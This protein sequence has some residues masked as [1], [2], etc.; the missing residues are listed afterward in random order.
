MRAIIV[1]G[2]PEAQLP[3]NIRPADGD[4]LVAVDLGGSHCLRWGWQPAVVIG[5]LDSLP[6][7]DEA[8]LRAM[9]CRF[10][11]VPVRKD[12]TDLELALDHAV[13]AGASEIVIVAAWGG[14]IDQSL[15]NVLLLTRPTLTGRDVRLVEGRQTVRLAQP[16]R[17]AWIEGLPGDVLSL[18]PVGG[19]ADGVEVDDVEW[20]LHGESLALGVTRGVSNVLTGRAVRV[21]VRSGMLVVTHDACPSGVQP[22]VQ[23]PG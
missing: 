16:G 6:A 5:D 13:Q 1:A 10:I 21:R 12:E 18:V 3:V 2:S 19:D 17:P 20:P 7:S 23:T 14:R 9:G 4:L 15:A 11:T 22:G 8:V